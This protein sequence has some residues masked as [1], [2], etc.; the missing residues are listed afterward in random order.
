MD[1]SGD[2][3]ESHGDLVP[4]AR[5][6]EAVR[7][8]ADLQDVADSDGAVADVAGANG[9][10]ALAMLGHCWLVGLRGRWRARP[11]QTFL[12]SLF[13]LHAEIFDGHP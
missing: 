3:P 5:T 6:A 12:V 7:V 13:A 9:L 2:V 8:T 4:G 1:I 11:E 10:V